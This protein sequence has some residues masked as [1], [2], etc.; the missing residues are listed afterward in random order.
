MEKDTTEKP[1]F[2]RDLI[3][4]RNKY[5]M[6]VLKKNRFTLSRTTMLYTQILDAEFCV[7]YILDVDIDSGDEDSYICHA[8]VLNSQPHI[9]EEQLHEAYKK[10][11]N[12][13][14]N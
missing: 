13:K 3:M 7:N 1:L 2:N 9:T 5:S 4:N 8:D 12:T 11:E 6:D 14:T 10:F